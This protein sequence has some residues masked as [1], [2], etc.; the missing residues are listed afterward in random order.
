MAMPTKS[1]T[2]QKNKSV[3]PNIVRAWFDTVLNPLLSEL[4]EERRELLAGNWSWR[5][6]R[7]RLLSMVPVREHIVAEAWDNLDQFLAFHPECRRLIDRHDH[8]VESLF[9]ACQS[10]HAA[11][12][13]SEA[14]R[15]ARGR[16]TAEVA[17][18]TGSSV[19]DLFG[20]EPAENHLDVLAEYIV[21]GVER[22]PRY[23]ATAPLWNEHAEDF[24]RMRESPGAR[25]H[26]EVTR[27]AGAELRRAVGDLS[28]YLKA[29]RDDLSLEYDLPF[30]FRI[31]PVE[32]QRR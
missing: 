28:A 16:R 17:R 32:P 4:A 5:S 30:M 7:P 13:E 12:T 18:D 26:W 1:R 24:L 23:C 27:G 14:L 20:A 3:G 9:R 25:P 29:A 15:E 19:P 6:R 11:L 22:L 21:N 10:F 8:R 31:S 2:S